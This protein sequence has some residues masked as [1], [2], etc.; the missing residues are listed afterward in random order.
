MLP[1]GLHVW[2]CETC[3]TDQTVNVNKGAGLS[4]KRHFQ[5][6]KVLEM[7]AGE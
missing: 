3:K 6:I 1:L 2:V 7:A 4:D 5:S